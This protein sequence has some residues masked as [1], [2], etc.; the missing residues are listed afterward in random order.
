MDGRRISRIRVTPLP[1][2]APSAPS[3]PSTPREQHPGA[4]NTSQADGVT[5]E[6]ES[7]SD[8]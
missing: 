1:Q 4:A 8:T 3:V 2:S 7:T 6:E 5:S